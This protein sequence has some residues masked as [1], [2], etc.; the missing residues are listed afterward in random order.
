LDGIKPI[1]ISKIKLAKNGTQKAVNEILNGVKNLDGDAYTKLCGEIPEFGDAVKRCIKG[2]IDKCIGNET[3][4]FH[5]KELFSTLENLEIAD[6]NT[7]NTKGKFGFS[8]NDILDNDA[9]SRIKQLKA[10]MK[11]TTNAVL[12]ELNLKTAKY[13]EEQTKVDGHG[14]LPALYGL[15]QSIGGVIMDFSGYLEKLGIADLSTPDS[16]GKF[17][18][19]L[20]DILGEDAEGQI[21]KLK[22]NIQNVVH[23]R[24]NTFDQI[25]IRQNATF[26]TA[27]GQLISLCDFLQALTINNL[28]N[29]DGKGPLGFLLEDILCEDAQTLKDKMKT[30]IVGIARSLP[31]STPGCDLP[32]KD[33][34]G[35]LPRFGI[36]EDDLGHRSVKPWALAVLR[37]ECFDHRLDLYI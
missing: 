5:L 4:T 30:A 22:T 29:T 16:K 18:F 1:L 3:N 37:L 36:N 8:L 2:K 28:S 13:I 10:N 15:D 33:L 21:G 14:N 23:S 34:R 11:T 12:G 24:L 7:P 32:L 20:N 26:D 25:V 35:C 31:E 17:G 9:E 6:L 19:S 27:K